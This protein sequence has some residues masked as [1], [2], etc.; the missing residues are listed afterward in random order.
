MKEDP[1]GSSYTILSKLPIK[2]P[3]NFVYGIIKN[4]ELMVNKLENY[5]KFEMFVKDVL[6]NL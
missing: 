2:I 4:S 6:R 3:K 5:E 1:E